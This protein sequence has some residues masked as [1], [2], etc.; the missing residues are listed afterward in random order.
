MPVI[1]L[2]LCFVSLEKNFARMQINPIKLIS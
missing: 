2:G 1:M